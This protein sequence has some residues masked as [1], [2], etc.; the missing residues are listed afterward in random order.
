MDRNVKIS[1][2]IPI[3]NTS[4]YLKKCIDSIV[5]QTIGFE[6]IELILV[7]DGSTDDSEKIIKKYL[8]KYKNIKYIY[9]EN[10]GQASARNKGLKISSGKYISFV[11]SDD[12][13]EL[14][15]YE[16]L[17]NI[18][19]TKK[20]DIATCDY[21]FLKA[22]KEEYV[23]FDFIEDSNKNF[24]VMNTGPCN[25]II[26]RELLIKENF[27]FPTGIIYEDL[28]SIPSLGINS[29]IFHIKKS[30]YN[31]LV[32]DNSTMNKKTYSVKLEDVFKSLNNLYNIFESKKSLKK[33]YSEVE[34]L[35]IRRLMMSASLRFIEHGD[36]NHCIGRIK[37][38]IDVKFPNWSKNKYYKKLPF[39]QRLVAILSYNNQ[40]LLLKI[41]NE[42]NSRRKK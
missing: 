34:F 8:K 35:Y 14:D 16:E 26:K 38:E 19:E 7:D 15:M 25:M 10:M 40:K 22:N 6:N 30:L 3:Y 28:A 23:S 13:I 12:Y 39:K 24:I 2:I 9:Q 5:N 18:C 37:N 31:Y 21:T 33:Y 41:L 11:D 20:I 42:L 36:P 27:E 32:R 4:Q 17:Y 29:K 1:T